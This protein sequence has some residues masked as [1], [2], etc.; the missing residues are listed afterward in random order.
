MF[1]YMNEDKNIIAKKIKIPI[2]NLVN[3]VPESSYATNRPYEIT[4]LESHMRNLDYDQGHPP[5]TQIDPYTN[6]NPLLRTL[7]RRKPPEIIFFEKKI[8]LLNIT[9]C[10]P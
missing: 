4:Y 8:V 6:N 3:T 2:V 1:L 7:G 9:E 10:D 5:M